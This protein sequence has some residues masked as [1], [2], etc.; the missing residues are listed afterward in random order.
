MPWKTLLNNISLTLQQSD[1]LRQEFKSAPAGWLGFPP[2][3]NADI[4]LA[5]Q[6]LGVALPPGYKDFLKVSNGFRQINCFN[7]DIL[8][9]EKIQW[10]KDFDPDFIEVWDGLE[11]MNLTDQEYF[12]YGDKQE[13]CK[14]RAEYLSKCLAIS[15]WGDSAI[16]LLN[17]EIKFG[18]E[19]EAWMFANWG[20]GATRYKS[21]EEL[22]KHEYS[23][24]T[25]I[26]S[27]RN[28]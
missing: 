5:E 27:N 16:L 24:Y 17:P 9:V 1:D 18:D 8:P 12:I 15:G 26:L 19:W 10:L 21:F 7:W 2:A 6:R 25:T 14:F 28:N 22:V 23:L 3:T 13:S 4:K 20:P 11:E